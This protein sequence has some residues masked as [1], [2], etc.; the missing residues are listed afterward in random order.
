MIHTWPITI[1]T[2]SPW[3]L[4]DIPPAHFYLALNMSHI[5]IRSLYKR[6]NC[7]RYPSCLWMYSTLHCFTCHDICMDLSIISQKLTCFKYMC[8]RTSSD[9]AS[10]SWIS[11]YLKTPSCFIE[12]DPFVVKWASAVIFVFIKHWLL[13]QIRTGL[14]GQI[15]ATII[16]G[17]REVIR[18]LSW[19]TPNSLCSS[20]KPLW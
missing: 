4:I 7:C 5:S 19:S 2:T 20:N 18:Q 17:K 9:P 12:Q 6:Y 16:F 14:W 1:V 8:V 15:M 13:N 11:I 10:L 3:C